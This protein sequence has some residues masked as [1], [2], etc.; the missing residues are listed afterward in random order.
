MFPHICW[1]FQ[2]GDDP[3]SANGPTSSP[4]EDGQM[5]LD[6]QWKWS[7]C[8]WW[9]FF[10]TV[11]FQ[12][13]DDGSKAN[14]PTS[15]PREDCQMW[16]V[17]LVIT[18]HPMSN[19]W[20][21]IYTTVVCFGG[22]VRRRRHWLQE[23]FQIR[24]IQGPHVHFQRCLHVRFASCSLSRICLGFPCSPKLASEPLDRVFLELRSI[25]CDNLSRACKRIH[26]WHVSASFVGTNRAWA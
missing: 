16:L 8:F 7:L 19:L 9:V 14:G 17:V 26:S 6:L 12:E 10:G 23:W 4:C 20:H 25:F 11:L 15:S 22:S 3:S 24:W 18:T 21:G 2:D 5:W 1:H 13:G